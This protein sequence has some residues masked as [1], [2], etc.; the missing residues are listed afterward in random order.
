MK[1]RYAL[2]SSF[3][4]EF[5]KTGIFTYKILTSQ[6]LPF[7]PDEVFPLLENPGKLPEITPKW[8]D[9]RVVDCHNTTVFKGAEFD[10]T[11]R[12]FGIKL[13]WRTRI[14][15]YQKPVR[16]TDIQV[17]GPYSSWQHIH[18]F[19]KLSKGTRLK[20]EVTYGIPLFAMPLHKI[21]IK[22]QLEDIFCF[23]AVRI[24]DLL[25]M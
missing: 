16:F 24:K 8:L 2:P 6:V 1:T 17:S 22:K 14:I 4:I 7:S 12:W 19:E 5:R 10:Y 20:D 25:S 13:R 21:I 3:T 11:I 15:D 9:F 18:T 23:R